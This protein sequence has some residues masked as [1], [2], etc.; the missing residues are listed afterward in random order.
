[1]VGIF[2]HN[3]ITFDLDGTLMQNPFGKWVFPHIDQKMNQFGLKE[4]IRQEIIKEHQQRMKEQKERDAYDWDDIVK[5]VLQRKNIEVN[6]DVEFLVQQ[7]A[8]YPKVWLLE[9]QTLTVLKQLKKKGY[10]LGVVTNGFYK[11][12]FPVM[13]ALGLSDVMDA[14]VTPCQTYYTKPNPKML[15]SFKRTKKIIA[16]VGDRLDHDVFFANQ[17][18]IS[19]ILIDH[20]LPEELKSLP[21]EKRAKHTNYFLSL[22]E[23]SI[24]QN[25]SFN[26]AYI[27]DFVIYSIAELLQLD[28]IRE[29]SLKDELVDKEIQNEEEFYDDDYFSFNQ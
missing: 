17:Q 27:P 29:Q 18:G 1:M 5:V 3:W 28:V 2:L 8:H 15:A 16:H 22:K 19:S 26:S 11:Y 24:Y 23:K 25:V 21:P 20:S 14:M 6:I 7:N 13:E 12:Q 10:L 4:G 9:D